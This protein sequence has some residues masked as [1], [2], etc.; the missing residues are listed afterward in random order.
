[1]EFT[2]Y[3]MLSGASVARPKATTSA[4]PLPPYLDEDTQRSL[5]NR[6]SR[7]EGHVRSVKDMVQKERPAEDILLQVAAIKAALNK[8]STSLLQHELETNV[9]PISTER[10]L[11]TIDSLKILLKQS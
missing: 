6:L 4:K 3:P 1:M 8:F 11:K 10:F 2:N 9:E 5:T 7:I